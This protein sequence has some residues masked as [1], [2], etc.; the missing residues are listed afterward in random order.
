MHDLETAFETAAATP[1]LAVLP[2]TFA[3]RDPR[4]IEFQPQL[5]I[6][7]MY[8]DLWLLRHT[9]MRGVERIEAITSWLVGSDVFG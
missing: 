6:A 7:N 5:E 1:T 2:T 8:R 9:D 4:L 3:R